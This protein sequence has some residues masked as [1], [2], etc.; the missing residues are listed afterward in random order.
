MNRLRKWITKGRMLLN[1]IKK[2]NSVELDP[3]KLLKDKRVV[4]EITSGGIRAVFL[5]NMSD[6]RFVETLAEDTGVR[7]GGALYADA[8]SGPDGPAPDLLSLFR[9]NQ[10]ELL[11]ALQ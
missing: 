1:P 9:H 3:K 4:E 7:V 11:K 6:P 2:G 8:L 5:E 10:G